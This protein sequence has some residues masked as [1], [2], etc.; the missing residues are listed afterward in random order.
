MW[1]FESLFLIS[2]QLNDI[3]KVQG[4]LVEVQ[5]DPDTD[6]LAETQLH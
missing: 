3:Q 4:I 1:S 5:R 6:I 2:W